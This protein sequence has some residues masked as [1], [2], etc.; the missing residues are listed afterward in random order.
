M[1]GLVG[2]DAGLWVS[3]VRYALGRSSYVVSWTIQ[4]TKRAWPELPEKVRAVIVRD[5][6]DDIAMAARLPRKLGMAIDDASWRG[7][8]DWARQQQHTKGDDT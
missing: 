6:A 4:E 7:F 8:L 2:I 1:T 3:V 5:I